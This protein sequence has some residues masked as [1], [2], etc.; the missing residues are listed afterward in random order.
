MSVTLAAEAAAEEPSPFLKLIEHL[1]PHH[2]GW[3][4]E[5][6]VGNVDLTPTSAV[7]NLWGAALLTIIIF[8]VAASKTSL[9]PKGLRNAIEVMVDFVKSNIVYSVM[10]AKDGKAWYPFIGTTFFFILMM[11]LVGLIPYFGF[12]PTSNI[13]VTAA[14]ALG[15]Y[16]MA[17][18]IG[19]ARHGVFTFWKKSLVPPDIPKAL[20]PLMVPIE[21]ISQL[22]RPF[23]LAVRLFA[24]MLADHVILL[25]FVGFI[26]LVGTSFAVGHVIVIPIA[27]TMEIVFTAFALFVAFIQ[28]VIF[29]FLTTIYIND[30]LHPGH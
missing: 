18:A 11:N 9:V 20:L 1:S 12:T 2:Y 5:I 19:M 22:A 21:I 3:A 17:V 28:A 27:M 25:I 23:S 15:I 4:P 24:N 13:W 6:K 8:A 26:F 7:L 30:A 10:S 16:L 29:S 14:L